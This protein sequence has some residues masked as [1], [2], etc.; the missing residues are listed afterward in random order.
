MA[1]ILVLSFSTVVSI[2]VGLR[3][4]RLNINSSTAVRTKSEK[5]SKP[6][7]TQISLST[8]N[9][10]SAIRQLISFVFGLAT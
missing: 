8:W 5:L 10:S 1:S 6:W 3:S 7:P 2:A 9:R 4:A